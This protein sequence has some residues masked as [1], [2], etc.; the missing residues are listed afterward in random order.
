SA[1]GTATGRPVG[2]GMYILNADQT[3]ALGRGDAV[4]TAGITFTTGAQQANNPWH[5]EVGPDNYLYIGDFSTNTGTIYR[6]D[7]DVSSASGELVLANYGVTNQSVH[8]T[9]GS[10]PII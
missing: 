5:I 7:P 4:S 6:T 1:A 2:D 9:I 8:T 10:S 3:D